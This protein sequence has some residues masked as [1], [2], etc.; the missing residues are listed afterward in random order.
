MNRVFYWALPIVLVS[1]AA[2][3]RAGTPRETPPPEVAAFSTA[4]FAERIG[5]NVRLG[6]AG[7]P[8]QKYEAIVKPRLL[9]LNVRLVREAVPITGSDTLA[10]IKDLGAAG[11][12]LSLMVKNNTALDVYKAVPGAVQSLE[13]DTPDRAPGWDGPA[14]NDQK[15]IFETIKHDANLKYIFLLGPGLADSFKSPAKLGDLKQYLDLGSIHCYPLQDDAAAHMPM[16]SLLH[17]QAT[18]VSKIIGPS[19]GNW[20]TELGFHNAA[21]V[22]GNAGVPEAVAARY[23]PRSLLTAVD[24]G[25]GE[26]FAYELLD[27]EPESKMTSADKHFGLLRVDGAPKPAFT[28]LKKLLAFLKDPGP[29]FTPESLAFKLDGGPK[30]LDHIL[31][32][33]R[34]GRYFLLL[35]NDVPCYDPKT[36]RELAVVPKEVTLTVGT[37]LE[38]AQVWYLL[39]EGDKPRPLTEL[40]KIKLPVNDEILVVEM[41]KKR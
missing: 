37:P 14:R 18:E 15:I 11:I 26:A 6:L 35:W 36:R 23:L 8:Y 13:L 16:R 33:R 21:D 34:D 17:D 9:E 2:S 4:M 41:T 40:K 38:K 5:I 1:F 39:R 22:P 12:K 25:F 20:V 19:G 32:Q 30:N 3:A 27:Q 7:S 31:M 29:A 28:A 10:K 24:M